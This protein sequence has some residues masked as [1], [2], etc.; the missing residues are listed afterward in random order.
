MAKNVL[1]IFGGASNENEVSVITG[2]M[3]ANVLKS[4]GYAVTPVYIAQNG[5][6]YADERFL[7]VTFFKNKGYLNSPGAAVANGG[8]YVFKKSGKVKNFVKV[9]V[10]LNCCHGGDCEGGAVCGLCALAGIP[11]ASAQTFESAAFM[12]KY[13]TKL[14]LFSLGVKTAEYA[15]VTGVAD[16]SLRDDLPPFPVIV[17][18]VSLGSSIGVEKCENAEELLAA[19][20]T[21]LCLDGAMIVERYI[22][23]RREINCAAYFYNGEVI[24]SECEEA[25]SCGELLSFEDKYQGGG[26]SVLPA[27]IPR[28]TAEKIKNTVKLVY[29]K[30]NMR[31]IVRF[32]F[33]LDDEEIIL[34]EVNTV[35][36]SL[37]YYL[38]SSGFKNFKTVLSA[39]IDQAERDF[40]DK[41]SKTLIYTGILENISSNTCKLGVK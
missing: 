27:D 3:A 18:P 38:L 11:L 20:K 5:G 17:K 21:A 41:K 13:L 7:D 30:L 22:E 15:Y 16:L 23:N 25:L 24:T 8:V 40:A 31:G 6:I 37:S 34:S 4:A 39:V 33:I 10:A 28:D 36:G 26:K 32:D 29:G 9:D 14:L 19:C 1:V 35:P 2:T 12:D